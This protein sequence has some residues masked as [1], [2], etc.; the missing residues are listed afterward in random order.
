MGVD[1]HTTEVAGAAIFHRSGP[2]EGTPVLY[3]HS[4]PTSCDDWVSMLALT[5]GTAPDLPGFGRSSKG[6]NLDYSPA[7]YAAFVGDFLD[8]CE[9]DEVALVGH[10]WGAAIGLMFAQAHPERVTRLALLDPVPLLPGFDWP[11]LVRWLRRPGIGELLMGSVTR[12]L[13]ARW[14][15]AGSARPQTWPD[16]RVDAVWEQF[17]QGTQRAILR[18]HRAADPAV[19]AAAGAGLGDL[20]QPVFVAWGEHDH[21]LDHAFAGAY[22]RALPASRTELIP[23]AGHWPWLEDPDLA[24]R[25]AA[26]ATG[27]G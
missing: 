9:L 24:G 22:A 15:R 4:V 18:L 11:G 14:L 20:H 21:W 25:L 8:A 2:A 13:L 19:L 16:A 27:D 23:S 5:G 1:E 10:G 12:G 7:A 3:L 17:D 26:F 6:G